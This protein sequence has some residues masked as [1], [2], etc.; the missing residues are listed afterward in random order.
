MNY[1]YSFN[2]DHLIRFCIM[3]EIYNQMKY[4]LIVLTLS[5]LSVCISCNTP[6]E[7]SNV[8]VTD[9]AIGKVELYDSSASDIININAVVEVIGRNYKWCEGPVWVASKQM[10]LFSAVRENQI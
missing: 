7:N 9:S 6:N 8:V 1:K 2:R 10:L 4:Q 5:Y 3:N